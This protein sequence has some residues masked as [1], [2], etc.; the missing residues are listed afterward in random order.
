MAP[1]MF[2]CDDGTYRQRHLRCDDTPDCPDQSDEIN[3]NS[4]SKLIDL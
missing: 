2:R 1:D 3:C 4:S